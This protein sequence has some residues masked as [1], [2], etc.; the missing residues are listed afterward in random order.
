MTDQQ[1]LTALY[2]TKIIAFAERAMTVLEPGT[3]LETSW[4]HRAICYKLELASQG[5]NRRLVINQPPKT[6]KTHLVS[7]AFVAWLLMHE[8]ALKIAIISYDDTLASK[9]LRAVRQIM[10]DPWYQALAPHTQVK[11]EKDTEYLFET[12]AGG[13]CRALSVQGGITGLGFDY[14][15]MDDPMKASN[16][17]SDAERARLEE[18]YKSAI[19]NR[20]RN[21]AKGVLIV[22]MQRL[23]VDDFTKFIL[24]A[25]GNAVH[26]SIPAIAPEDLV[27]ELGDG[28]TH[29]FKKGDL[30]EPERLS[31]AF[32]DEM[33][34]LQGSAHFE[35]QY[36]QDPQAS[37][38]RII[39]SEWFCY[40]KTARKAD[41]TVISIDPAFTKDG[42]DYSAALV[43]NLVDDDI[44]ITHA[45]QGQFDYPGLIHWF[46]KMDK[47]W[48]PDVFLVEAI[49][50]G[51][52]LP[53]YMRQAEIDHLTFIDTHKG[54]SKTERMEIAS[55]FIEAGHL[56]LP[57]KA[58]WLPLLRKT[59]M[60]FPYGLSND[61]PDALSQLIIYLRDI[62]HA[63]QYHRNRRFPPEP[64]DTGERRRSMYYQ[65]FEFY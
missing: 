33:R 44:E 28:K 5:P 56:W 53:H 34:A 38:G 55:P 52:G 4:H 14:I 23:H 57:E 3:K 54:R 41:F 8:P 40:F 62:R 47:E 10:K 32:L 46:K 20:W 59:L 49:G 58:D 45:E 9:Q 63:A 42:G 2:R 17:Y 21:P 43:V 39:K 29:L 50:A 36:L 12:T 1:T 60:D 65:R 30:L 37:G 35:A 16:G 22:V 48:S 31:Q 64:I 26:L 25:A 13:E 7:V 18:H 51:M 61:W 24:K 15:I 19:A 6:L 27:F 11:P